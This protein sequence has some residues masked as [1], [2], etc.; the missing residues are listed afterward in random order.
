MASIP[1][2]KLP[3]GIGNRLADVAKG[4]GRGGQTLRYF[5]SPSI[6]G[7]ATRS[8]RRMLRANSAAARRVPMLSKADPAR[9]EQNQSKKLKG[10]L[11]HG[12]RPHKTSAARIVERAKARGANV[13]LQ[14]AVSKRGQSLMRGE[15]IKYRQS[16]KGLAT[17]RKG[18]RSK[19]SHTMMSKHTDKV[20]AQQLR[21]DLGGRSPGSI[22]KAAETKAQGRK[23]PKGVR[24]VGQMIKPSQGG[25]G[26]F[27]G[28]R[29][30]G[31]GMGFNVKRYRQRAGQY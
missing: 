10:R 21:H 29:P 20:Q 11:Q 9:M 7:G 5:R 27:G 14:E 3:K 31:G 8:S 19:E 24:S 13:S 6:E 2:K 4:R 16:R 1:K 25:G 17:V 18:Y 15:S 28:R 12:S 22:L 23:I 30:S 26:S